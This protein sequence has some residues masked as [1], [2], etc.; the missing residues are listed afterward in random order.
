M[1]INGKCERSHTPSTHVSHSLHWTGTITV[2]KV[3]STGAIS[4]DFGVILGLWK[5]DICFKMSEVRLYKDL[6]NL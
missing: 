1:R 2:L 6:K 4:F 5:R 3:I